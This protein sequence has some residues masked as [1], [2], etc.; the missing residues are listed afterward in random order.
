[1]RAMKQ[2]MRWRIAVSM[3]CESIELRPSGKKVS[4]HCC[5]I[6]MAWDAMKRNS[7]LRIG[8]LSFVRDM[9]LA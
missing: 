4:D 2:P 3:N 1:M 8:W 5:P 7:S 6:K 9:N